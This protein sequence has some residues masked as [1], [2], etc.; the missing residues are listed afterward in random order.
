MFSQPLEISAGPGHEPLKWVVC[1]L[2]ATQHFKNESRV[3]FYSVPV[4]S[5]FI[6]L[7]IAATIP[8]IGLVGIGPHERVRRRDVWFLGLGALG[9][10]ALATLICCYGLGAQQL[11]RKVMLELTP[12]SRS[13]QTNFPAEGTQLYALAQQ[14]DHQARPE[15]ETTN[16][17]GPVFQRRLLRHFQYLITTNSL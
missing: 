2:V 7:F 12:L 10:A 8:F 4:A 14:L 17:P 3:I 5:A 13:I 1:G 15:N 6:V 9:G 11:K 16:E